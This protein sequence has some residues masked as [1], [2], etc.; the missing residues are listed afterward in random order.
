MNFQLIWGVGVPS[1]VG[2]EA[3]VWGV[4]FKTQYYLP[5]TGISSISSDSLKPEHWPGLLSNR[6]KRESFSEIFHIE[7][8]EKDSALTR[9]LL[10]EMLA[11]MSQE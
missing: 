6:G 5:T 2:N 7:G 3:L 4:V 8:K 9:W 10:Y 1:Q 11:K